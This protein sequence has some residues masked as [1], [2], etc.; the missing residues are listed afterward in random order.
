M[1]TAIDI[2]KEAIAL[3]ERKSIDYQGSRWTESDYFPFG[4]QSYMHM[5]HTKYLRMR[6]VM[7]S[8]E[9]NFESLE[10]TLIDMIN[11]S[12]MYAAWLRNRDSILETDIQSQPTSADPREEFHTHPAD[13]Y[14]AK[15]L[16]RLRGRRGRT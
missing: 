8:N 5:I 6:N 16:D 1:T 4:D 12:A 11:Y 13:D 2:M 9:V 7:D 15:D 10:D 3:K 14:R